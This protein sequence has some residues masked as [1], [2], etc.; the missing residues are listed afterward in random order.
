MPF[1]LTPF[2]AV[3]LD[4]AKA[5]KLSTYEV[6]LFVNNITPTFATVIGDYVESSVAG[7]A[8]Q[9]WDFPTGAVDN[10]D[11]T[12]TLVGSVL[13]WTPTDTLLTEQIYGIFVT[14]PADSDE[15]VG[16][17]RFV[18]APITWGD[19]LIPFVYQ[20]RWREESIP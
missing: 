20:P 19:T 2:G 14:D 1:I 16:G 17:G 10:L 9:L 5:A 6:H 12:A 18:D 13:I 7:Y 8:P 3:S 15:L 4:D 11:G